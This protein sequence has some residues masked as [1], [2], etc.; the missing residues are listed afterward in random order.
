[1]FEEGTAADRPFRIDGDQA[2]GPGV[3]DMKSGLLVGFF[4]V[5]LLLEAGALQGSVVYVCN[6]DEEVGSPFS[7]PI[8]REAAEEADVALVLEPARSGGRVVTARK[9]VSDLRIRVTGRSAHAGVEPEKGASAVLEAAH[10]V[11]ALHALNGRWPE[12]TVNAGEVSGGTRPNVVA[13]R[14][15]IHVDIRA[16][17][18]DT[19]QQAERAALLIAETSTVPGTTSTVRLSANHRPME[20]TEGTAR[21]F[22]A[23]RAMGA[24]L[25]IDIGE[26]ATGGASDANTTSAAGTPTLDG[27]GPVGGDAHTPVEWLDLGSV[28]PRVALMAALIARAGEIIEPK[29]A[30]E[31]ARWS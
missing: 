11:V 13:E 27:L 22:E 20:R 26:T 30:R 28:V 24:E 12:V 16:P 3:C 4:A 17:D 14:S 10:K 23:A 18:E 1:V 8:I 7:K 21:L 9:G 31:E 29:G 19:L 6:P 25:G 2:Y 5:E 15:S